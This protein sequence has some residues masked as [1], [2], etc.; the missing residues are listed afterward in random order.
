MIQQIETA[1]RFITAIAE[2]NPRLELQTFK[3]LVIIAKQPGICRTQLCQKTGVSKGA[4]TRNVDK[5]TELGYVEKYGDS[6][7]SRVHRCRLT[8][9]GEQ[10]IGRL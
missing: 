9:K 5:L 1:E 7:D 4:T 3:H 8:T 2:V 10:L 6:K